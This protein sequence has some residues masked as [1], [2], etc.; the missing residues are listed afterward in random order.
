M[1]KIKLNVAEESLLNK[2]EMSAVTGGS[3]G[4]GCY[5]ENNGGSS[6]ADNASANAAGGLHSPGMTHQVWE[7]GEDGLL[8]QCDYWY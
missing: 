8:H 2:K 4:C 5:Y 3:C 6:T 7:I 1:R